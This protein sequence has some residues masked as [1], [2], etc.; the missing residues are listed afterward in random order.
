MA[1]HQKLGEFIKALRVK[2]DVTL[3]T[4]CLEN[5]IDAVTLSK[6][7]RGKISA[8]K[9]DFIPNLAKLLGVTES[10][11]QWHT[12]MRMAEESRQNPPKR[13]SDKELAGKLPILFRKSNGEEYTEEELLALAETVREA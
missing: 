5:K 12:L 13:M 11:N 10:S 7:E 3:R 6:L 1:V 4:F 2:K 8:P 9:G